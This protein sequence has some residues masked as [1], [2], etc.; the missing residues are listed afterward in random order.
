M[1]ERRRGLLALAAGGAGLVIVLG[2]W[3]A[4]PLPP[5][6]LAPPSMPSFT[7]AD[8]HG[9]ALRTTRAPDGTFARPVPLAE[10]DPK[11]LQAFL[12]L[13]DRRFFSHSGV[14]WRAVLRAV[15]DNL[16]AGHVVS[17]ASTITMQLA[18]LLEPEANG[19]TWRAK[20]RQVL[21][22]W[23]LEHHL[24]KQAILEQYLNRVPLG[25][26]TVGVAEG[27]RLYFDASPTELSLGQAALL[28]A[29][30]RT[31]SADNPFV[32]PERAR[33]RRARALLEMRDVGYAAAPDVGRA[34]AEPLVPPRSAA[35]FL[36]PHFTSRLLAWNEE[37]GEPLDGVRLTALDLTLQTALEGEVRHTVRVM[38]DRGAEQAAAVV[39]DN[40]TGELLAWVG[41]PDFW[42]DSVGQVDMVVS[43]R[44]PGSA[45]KPFL[46]ALAFDR[47]Y[48]P[49]SVLPDVPHTY[50]TPTGPYRPRN[51]DRAFHGPVRVREALA[52]SYN[53]PAVELT[54][55]LGAPSLLRTMQLAGF[56]SLDRTADYYGLGLALGN[57]DVTLLELA[58]AY[59]ALAN[60]GRWLPYRWWVVPRGE[61]PDTAA[62]RRVASP[63][64]AALVL[65]ILAD[66]VARA[67]GF[68][69]DTPF[70]FPF[71]VAV[72]TGT[73]RHFT[74]NWA[75]GTT[76]G[77]TVAVWV[78]N[79]SGRPMAG[80]SGVT[81]AGPLLHRAVML[82][83]EH[84]APGTLPSPAS[85]GAVP[86]KV[87]RLSGLR[88]RPECPALIEWFVPGT[89]PAQV[90]D[91]H[92]DASVRLPAEYAEWA[93][94]TGFRSDG[95]Q[96]AP[97]EE[98]VVAHDPPT[99]DARSSRQRAPGHEGFRIVSPQDGD[100]YRVPPG[101]NARYATLALRVAGGTGATRWWVDGR[102]TRAARWQLVPGAHT[103]W[104]VTTAG[105]SDEVRIVVES[106]PGG[107]PPVAQ[108]VEP[109]QP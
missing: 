98:R 45:L 91:W 52:S 102:P 68:G 64:A 9:L 22:A 101:V 40:H 39:L 8:R 71:P 62:G 96:A 18:R 86:V 5:G 99:R 97:S 26:G 25:Q 24:T 37:R 13:E 20:L 15:R 69:L 83:A 74:D 82:T 54:D 90:C 77:F 78:G 14:D 12:A 87:C 60:G 6:L 67:P 44:Q 42:A 61:R 104:A 27:A 108:Q 80:V 81:G 29:L 100:T 58:N 49:A 30:A 76:A 38:G 10:L 41:S 106:G 47:G 66:P 105:D 63:R 3:V 103:I 32:A 31:P 1:S 55:R 50:E 4:W 72:K 33:H 94:Q 43:P 28:G 70:D 51:Y 21:W 2:A 48:T 7:L 95:A 46:Y 75:V 17:G 56:A 19:R 88:A 16:R 93:E 89:E 23:R 36:A 92:E 35:V 79:F 73:S 57:G 109:G 53:V 11:I 65:D 59:R 107:A 85:L 34:L 84:Y